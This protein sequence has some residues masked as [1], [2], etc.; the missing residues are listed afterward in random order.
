MKL[1]CYAETLLKFF[2]PNFKKILSKLAIWTE[3]S[4][5]DRKEVNKKRNALS[6]YQK[7]YR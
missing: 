5:E 6:R 7:V 1:V 2:V 4:D 3:F